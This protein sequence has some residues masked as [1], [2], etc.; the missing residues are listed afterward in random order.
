MR[1]AIVHYWLVG[2]RGG[3]RVIHTLLELF[4]DAD[5]F[6]HVYDRKAVSDRITNRKVTTTFIQKLP[7]SKTLY[8][9]YLPLMPLA[10]EQLDLRGYDL[11]ISSESGPAKGV[12]ASSDCLHVCYCHTPMRYLWGMYHDYRR[13]VGSIKRLVMAPL[14]HYL[15]LWDVASAQ[16]VDAFIA[17]SKHVARR[18]RRT[19]GR[20][21]SVIYPP[22]PVDAFDSQQEHENYYL[23]VGQLV[24]YKRADLAVKSFNR[25]NK[26][27][28][29]IGEGDQRH[30]LKKMA[31]PNIEFKNRQSFSA[32]REYYAKCRA[33]IF[34]G[35]EDF[36]M[37][38]V[39]AMASGK[40][41]IAFKAGGALE[42]VIPDKTGVL[43]NHQTEQCLVEA[44]E[45]FEKNK[46][47]FSRKACL[48]Q[49]RRF[50]S[51]RF[52][53]EFI[54]LIDENYHLE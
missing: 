37:V 25:L 42:T 27:L 46:F 10:L 41:V 23:M 12:L 16:R 15:R 43:F 7:W 9:S 20:E 34:P 47:L 36:G 6:T 30:A 21:A 49:A 1:V 31:K 3:E 14:F 11:V 29:I 28:I 51:K 45:Y 50:D 44:I 53:S 32:I 17:N 52:K 26:R 18:I 40:P 22:V 19:Y 38:P 4:P 8:Q 35:Q 24:G 33:V 48:D 2:M 5:L 54:K 13:Q 39:E